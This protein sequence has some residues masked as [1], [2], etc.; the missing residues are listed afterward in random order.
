MKTVTTSYTVQDFIAALERKEIIVNRDYQR[1]DEV[2][3][4][5]ARSYLI[6]T[7]LLDYPIPK[8]AVHQ[9]T[10][11]ATGKSH[12]ELVDGQQRAA[13][14]RAFYENKFALSSA[15]EN[16]DLRGLKYDDLDID[17]RTTFL[18]YQLSVDLFLGAEHT[19]I[20]EVFRRINSYTFPLNAEEQRHSKYQGAFKWFLHRL[21]LALDSVFEETGVFSQKQLA[22]MADNKLLAEI[23]HAMMNGITTT[24]KR[25]LDK[26]YAD[27]DEEFED[28]EDFEE[29]LLAG[30]IKLTEWEDIHDTSIMKP[31]QVYSLVLAII[32]V[33]E[34]IEELKEVFDIDDGIEIDNEE[35][36]KR[37]A[38]LAQAI[39]DEVET[40]KY[41]AFVLASSEKTNVKA[42]RETRFKYY[43]EALTAE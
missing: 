1:S 12:K 35:A 43:C 26:L 18:N 23:C 22:R 31:F 9:V 40:G 28:E 8:L 32:H 39:D 37:L 41:A 14:I 5:A 13:T 10:D 2:W 38:R 29:R 16:K 4:D 3:P 7:V 30:V 42:E 21:G 19:Q 6:E 33:T 27:H 11:A 36:V 24:N 20:R 17:Q 25:I 15:V 34:P